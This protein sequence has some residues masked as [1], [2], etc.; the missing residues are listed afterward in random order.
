MT[1]DAGLALGLQSLAFALFP[2]IFSGRAPALAQPGGGGAGMP[3]QGPSDTGEIK[4]IGP[5]FTRI[6]D[7]WVDVLQVPDAAAGE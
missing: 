6:G 1:V 3:A 4:D 5:Y 2:W 7:A